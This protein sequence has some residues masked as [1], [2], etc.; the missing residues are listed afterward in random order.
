MI[1]DY[2]RW[3][4][5]SLYPKVP[6]WKALQC[7]RQALQADETLSKRTDWSVDDIMKLLEI[8]LETHFLK[9]A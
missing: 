4:Q 8:C 7:T 2:S 6:L 1:A 3:I 9:D 5:K